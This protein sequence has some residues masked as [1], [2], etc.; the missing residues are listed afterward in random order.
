MTVTVALYKSYLSFLFLYT[1]DQKFPSHGIKTNNFLEY[2]FFFF[3]YRKNLL[4]DQQ[5]TLK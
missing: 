5:F 1:W 4:K 3:K 2:T